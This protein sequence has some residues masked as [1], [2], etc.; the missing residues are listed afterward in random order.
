MRGRVHAGHHNAA[1]VRHELFP[2]P[3]LACAHACMDSAPRDWT[4]GQPCMLSRVISSADAKQ[5]WPERAAVCHSQ[6][7][8]VQGKP[9]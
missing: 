6:G 7:E 1:H 8:S 2:R 9:Q 4:D 3:V 5:C